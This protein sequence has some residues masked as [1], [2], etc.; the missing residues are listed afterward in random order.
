MIL[1]EGANSD[2]IG[3]IVTMAHGMNMSVVAEGVETKVQRD[4]LVRCG[5]DLLQGYLFSRPV[6]EI[7]A[8]GILTN[9]C[10][11]DD[12]SVE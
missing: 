11:M 5:C 7:E 3:T 12:D 6:P 1:I 10:S 9:G 4:F 2:I 8:I